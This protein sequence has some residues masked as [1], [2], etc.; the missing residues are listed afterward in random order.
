M[1]LTEWVR[2]KLAPRPPERGRGQDPAPGQKRISH[3]TSYSD[4]VPYPSSAIHLR[5]LTETESAPGSITK[6]FLI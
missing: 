4:P 5:T 1:N 2:G 6:G 3:N